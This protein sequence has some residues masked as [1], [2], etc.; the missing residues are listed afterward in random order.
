MSLEFR[1]VREM[2]GMLVWLEVDP[3]GL[4]SQ[5]LQRE[6]K[7]RD[8][9]RIGGFVDS[10]RSSTGSARESKRRKDRGDLKMASVWSRLEVAE[11]RFL[12]S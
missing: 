6:C 9:S 4:K 5:T 2:V 7:V 3:D 1:V 8:P 12:A 10:R 11:R